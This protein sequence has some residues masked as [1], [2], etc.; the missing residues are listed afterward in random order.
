MTF[1]HVKPNTKA[2]IRAKN[3]SAGSIL[4]DELLYQEV[5]SRIAVPKS[6]KNEPK[7]ERA[8]KYGNLLPNRRASGSKLEKIQYLSSTPENIFPAQSIIWKNEPEV[9]GFQEHHALKGK[10][11]PDPN[12]AS[13]DDIR[14]D[15][16]SNL[17][18]D[19][20]TV[21]S[22]YSYS[23]SSAFDGYKSVMRSRND[24]DF[25][26]INARMTSKFE[27]N[28]PENGYSPSFIPN[29]T[30][31]A[32]QKASE[33]QELTAIQSYVINEDL[34]NTGSTPSGNDEN[35]DIL[36]DILGDIP[37]I[38]NE[39][40]DESLEIDDDGSVPHG[41]LTDS[42][43]VKEVVYENAV[44]AQRERLLALM[45]LHK[46]QCEEAA[47]ADQPHWRGMATLACCCIILC[48]FHL[49]INLFGRYP[50]TKVQFTIDINDS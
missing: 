9:T 49:F 41:D 42:V 48:V 4:D 12:K 45:A 27:V 31:P 13:L 32:S 40:E 50:K 15:S 43:V 22:N 6:F 47:K 14:N 5:S 10:T 8:K 30:Q 37:E 35:Y 38:E 18:S 34:D 33:I 46:A 16:V 28:Q 20:E 36:P 29:L 26:S 23:E 21:L 17:R 24:F 25:E 2:S 1:S 11:S 19:S 44:A 7:D 3:A 39:Y